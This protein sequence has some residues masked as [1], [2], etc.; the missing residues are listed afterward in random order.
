MNRLS[1]LLI[2]DDAKACQEFADCVEET[3]DFRLV[4]VTNNAYRA[5]EH[6]KDFLPDVIV[7]D[8]ELH[9]GNGNG[10]EFLNNLGAVGLNYHPY[11]LVTTNNTSSITY[12]F[13]RQSGADF[14][15]SKHQADYSAASVL[16]FLRTLK[17][18]IQNQ[19]K[20]R[21]T[22]LSTTESPAQKSK[23]IQLR[24]HSELDIIGISPKAVG[25]NYLAD[26]IELIMDSPTTNLCVILAERYHKSDASIERAMQNAINRAWRT[27]DPEILLKN[28]T[29]VINSDRGAP[30]L[31][32][33]IYYYAKKIK[34]E[35]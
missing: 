12:D 32:E 8:L 6:V 35:Y 2:E 30:T 16:S 11:I 31:N 26:A 1:V 15:M 23:R 29:A 24:I 34:D 14:I 33:F 19:R 18:T 20:S 28:Y 25:Y 4:G 21:S 22:L 10:L 27:A 13:A 9:D 7:L 5:I 3:D 17:T